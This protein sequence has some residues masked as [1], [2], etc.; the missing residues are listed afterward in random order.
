MLAMHPIVTGAL[1]ILF[2]VHLVAFAW[3]GLKRRE[4][5]YLAL[6]ITF[7]LLSAAMATLLAAPE[8]LLGDWPLHLILRFGAWTAAAITLTWTALRVI[9]RRRR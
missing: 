8:Q 3:L 4:L 1:L 9:R 2:L 6:V 7:T 5:Y